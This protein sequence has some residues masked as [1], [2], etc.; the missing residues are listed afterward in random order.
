VSEGLSSGQPIPVRRETVVAFIGPAPRGP[1]GI[2]VSIDGVDACLKRFGSPGCDSPLLDA[3]RQFFANGGN[4]AIVV[5]VCRSVRRHRIVLDG[6]SGVLTLEAI[7]PGAHELLRASVDYD[8]IPSADLDRFNLVVHRLA[9]HDRPIVEQ[10]EIFCGLSTD[11]ADPDFIA[12]ALLNSDLIRVNDQIPEQRPDVTFLSGIEVG[13]SYVYADP[14]WSESGCLTDYD[15]IGCDKESTGLFALDQVPSVDLVNLVSDAP[16]LGPVAL[17]TAERYCRKRNAMLLID[18]PTHWRSVADA[19]QS[20]RESGFTSANVATYFPRPVERDLSSTS[21]LGALAGALAARDACDGVWQ[22]QENTPLAIRGRA[23]PLF[24]I[25]IEE[26]Y[27]LRRAGIN[28]LRP[29]GRSRLELTGM[30]T[31]NRGGGCVTEWDD[32]RLRR[33]VLFIIDGI[34][35]G[36]RWAAFQ[37]GDAQTCIELSEQVERY[38]HDLFAVGALTGAKLSEAGHITCEQQTNSTVDPVGQPLDSESGVSFVVGFT[39]LEHGMQRFRFHQR[40]VEC[41]V[42]VLHVEHSIALA[43]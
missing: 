26:Q 9:S 29:G 11:P 40:P 5:R 30:V 10:Q 31:M 22:S 4:D 15:L 6:P 32:L 3:M 27:A 19:I 18:P 20:A 12:H 24:D 13:T 35:R 23:R 42:Q 14:D 38:L 43:S 39:P 37:R 1:V 34:A 17:F 25:D 33:T 28:A 21:A 7:N 36:T 41:Q 8:G 16:D 2:P